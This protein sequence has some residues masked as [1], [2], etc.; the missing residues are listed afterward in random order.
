V[1]YLAGEMMADRL[2]MTGE[3][4]DRLA[5]DW[6]KKVEFDTSKYDAPPLFQGNA[7]AVLLQFKAFQ[8]KNI[9][10]IIADAKA[11][12]EG[13]ITG[14][15]ARLAKM[16][17]SQVAIGGLNSIPG[18]ATLGGLVLMGAMT[19]AIKGMGASDEVSEKAA[20]AFYYGLPALVGLDF[21]GSV[22]ILDAPFGKTMA[23]KAVNYLG[24]PTGS[25]IVKLLE[26]G[27]TFF[28][29]EDSARGKSAEEKREGALL[30]T[31]KAITPYTKTAIAGYAAAAGA[32]G[33][34]KGMTPDLPIGGKPVPMTP[35]E[36]VGFGLMGTPVRQ[37]KFYDEEDMP[38]WQKKLRGKITGQPVKGKAGKTAARPK[39]PAPTGAKLPKVKRFGDT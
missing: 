37:S 13:S 10:R 1:G 3:A 7:A 4:K 6:A 22:G 24:G 12:P 16:V 29:A 35:T 25:T 31:A 26:E 23:E 39:L 21:S 17:F 28:E 27:K 20:E 19:H 5:R 30:R 15:K 18:S 38:D 34:R 14:K 2:G 33:K 8:A 11:A 9:E 36:A 32:L